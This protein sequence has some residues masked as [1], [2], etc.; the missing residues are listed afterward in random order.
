MAGAEAVGASNDPSSFDPHS[1]HELNVALRV[2]QTDD[3]ESEPART[4][5]QRRA[6]A[7]IDI[8]R[9][10]LDHQQHRR[11]GRCV[12]HRDRGLPVAERGD[13][14]GIKRLAVAACIKNPRARVRG[15]SCENLGVEVPRR[16]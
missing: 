1:G 5:G 2:A 6:D 3:V 13:M 4:P 16:S 9:Y 11:G 7:L 10:F 14:P 15:L 12:G 8:C